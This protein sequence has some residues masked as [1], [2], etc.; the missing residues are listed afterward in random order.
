MSVAVTDRIE[1]H[2]RL[3]APLARVWHALT[4][5]QEFG[6]WFGVRFAGSFVAGAPVHG[7]IAPTQVD[8]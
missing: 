6:R 3:R 1:K 5:A 8:A 7:V 2:V 4:D